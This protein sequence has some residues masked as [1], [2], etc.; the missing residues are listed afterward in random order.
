MLPRPSQT[1]LDGASGAMESGTEFV[2]GLDH[3]TDM[4]GIHI[5]P[6]TMAQ[7]EHMA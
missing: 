6:D 1:L 2:D 3:G 7:I 4:F 5:R